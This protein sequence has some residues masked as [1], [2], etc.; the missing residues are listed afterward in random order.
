MPKQ[1]WIIAP[2]LS[3]LFLLG[4]IG[5]S[6]WQKSEEIDK[7]RDELRTTHTAANAASCQSGTLQDE[8][9]RSREMVAQLQSERENAQRQQSALEQQMRTALESKDIT[10][11]ELQGR[12]TVNI[13]DRV[14]FDSGEAEVR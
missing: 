1:T 8:L 7:L 3:A 4:I 12:L 14:L 10:I 9:Q 11:S 13:V 2:I 5:L 6:V